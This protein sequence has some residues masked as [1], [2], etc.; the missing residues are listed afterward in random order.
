M[1]SLKKVKVAEVMTTKLITVSR[2]DT[3]KQVDHIFH[4]NRIH[5]LPVTDAEGNLIGILS[6]TDYLKASHMLSNFNQMFFEEVEVKDIMNVQL[7]VLEPT[8]TLQF[9]ID[10][11]LENIFHALPVVEGARLVGL[12]TTHDM[13]R[14]LS[15]PKPLLEK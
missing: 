14:F 12:V 1:D 2:T 15:K 11:F 9:A 6:K 4:S 13:L 5:H 3:L 8:D 7:A 10:I